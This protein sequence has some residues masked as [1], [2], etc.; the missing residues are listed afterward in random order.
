MTLSRLLL[1]TTLLGI[2]V[3]MTAQAPATQTFPYQPGLDPATIRK[4]LA[5]AWP[6]YSGDYTSRRFS[7]LKQVDRTTVKG[8]TLA[9]IAR[10]NAGSPRP[11]PGNVPMTIGGEGT[12]EFAATGGSTIKGGILAVN[13]ILY[14]TAP[15]NVW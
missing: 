7:T 13:D 15:D 10:V 3:L 9:W 4:P 8:L 2:P 1:T 12:G 6:T 5:D 14:V 11:T